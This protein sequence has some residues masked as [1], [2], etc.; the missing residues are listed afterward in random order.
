MDIISIA[1]NTVYKTYQQWTRS[2]VS[3][4]IGI[5]NKCNLR[6]IMCA[7][8]SLE[9]YPEY[10]EKEMSLNDFKYIINQF[11]RLK[12]L[13]MT[14]LGENLLNKDFLEMLKFAK[15]KRLYVEFF[16]NFYFLD[17]KISEKLIDIGV[18][19]I[20]A[21]IDGAT[22]ETYEK[23]RIGSNFNRVVANVKN[24]ILLK[25]T[26]KSNL[27]IVFNYVI[28]K[29]NLKETVK[30]VELVSKISEREKALIIFGR[31]LDLCHEAK[32]L[33]FNNNLKDVVL[34][35]NKKAKELGIK[36]IWANIAKEKH[37]IKKC[38][39]RFYPVITVNG[40]FF[41]CCIT[42]KQESFGNIFKKS[43][44]DIINSKDYKNFLKDINRGIAP[45]PCKECE[46]YY[47]KNSDKT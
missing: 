16:D 2:P 28:N 19:K 29:Y 21:S 44:R 8:N 30:F 5:T 42:K 15:S 26:K 27:N 10:L 45:D 40:E 1:K 31:V 46:L 32:E 22:K 25:K 43:A 7:R 38:K 6:C 24:L 4:Q 12:I 9:K 11:P 39:L 13:S 37:P 14:G 23:I 18:D 41:G 36:V 34:L 33:Y 47:G 3:L 35:T 20:I 17:E